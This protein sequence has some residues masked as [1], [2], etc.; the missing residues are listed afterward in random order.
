MVARLHLGVS[1]ILVKELW[2]RMRGVRAFAILTGM[3]LLTT[4][5]Y[6][7]WLSK[8]EITRKVIRTI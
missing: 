8:C 5:C 6:W 1:P 4:Y 2:S 3:L 7:N